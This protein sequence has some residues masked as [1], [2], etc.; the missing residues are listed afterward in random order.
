MGRGR[1][2]HATNEKDQCGAV[3]TETDWKRRNKIDL[4]C[5]FN[6][7]LTVGGKRLCSKHAMLEAIAILLAQGK[8]Q[9]NPRPE[10]RI[11]WQAVKTVEKKP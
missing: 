9:I 10:T 5:P 1:A 3:T 8:A 7:R 11:P 6:A 2:L 4:R